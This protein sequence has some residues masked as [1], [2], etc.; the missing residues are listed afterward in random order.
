MH[1]LPTVPTIFSLVLPYSYL[2]MLQCNGLGYHFKRNFWPKTVFFM[3]CN[4]IHFA[5]F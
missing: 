2:P 5:Y 1:I 4:S 3:Q